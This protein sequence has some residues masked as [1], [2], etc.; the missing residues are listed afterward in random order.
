[1]HTNEDQILS[2]L[3]F[4]GGGTIPAMAAELDVSIGTATKLVAALAE[5]G[6]IQDSGVMETASG[7]KPHRFELNPEAGYFL[8]IDISDRFLGFGLMDF[9]GKLVDSRLDIPYSLQN[10]PQ[11]LEKVFAETEAVLKE[12]EVCR[13]RI[14]AIGIS[15]PGRVSMERG[16]SFTN[17]SFTDA[18]LAD[19]F[20]KRLGVPAFLCNDTHAMTFAEYMQDQAQARKNM[21]YI[22]V[23][24][25]LGAG[26]LLDGKLYTGKSGFA[27]ELG[28]VHGF[29]N[30]VLC[31][32]GKKGCLETEISGQALRRLL[33]ERIRA[34]ESSILSRRVLTDSEP[35]SLSEIMNAVHREDVL[36]IDIIEGIGLRLGVQIAGL[37]NLFNPEL[38]V[39]GGELSLAGDYLL[40]PIKA[41]VNK[42]SLNLVNQDTIIRL[43]S[44]GSDGAPLAACLV[45][46]INSHYHN[47]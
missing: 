47:L 2:Y 24:W 16:K 40:Q 18:P 9:A 23:N 37:I 10:T 31:R 1:M 30:E 7:R 11:S 20:R 4:N 36:C 32:C 41:A 45:A 42:Y 27:G 12:W 26:I 35:L 38:V 39:V 19:V 44:L 28:H 17:L 34:G 25:G 33:T 15:L 22:N 43:S 5:D 29:D 8:G 14:R 3:I 21:I 6:L 13:P 46:R